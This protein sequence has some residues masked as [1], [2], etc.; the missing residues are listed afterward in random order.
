MRLSLT[1]CGGK[2]SCC[3]HW[4][5]LRKRLDPIY[6]QIPPKLH[7]K[8]HLAD[9][10]RET[11]AKTA[12][13]PVVG[14]HI[15]HGDFQVIDADSYRIDGYEWPAVPVW[16]YEK[17]MEALVRKNPGDLFFPLLHR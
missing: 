14:V 9:A 1:D 12:G 6:M 10:V 17:A 2:R 13:R 5:A 4:T 8:Q 7:L 11:F 15:R 3:A 16:W